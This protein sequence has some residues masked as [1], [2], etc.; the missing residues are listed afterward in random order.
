MKWSTENVFIDFTDKKVK[1]SRATVRALALKETKCQCAKCKNT[2]K[3]WSEKMV[4]EL[5]H[6][7]GNRYNHKKDNLEWLC[8][9]CHSLTSNFRGRKN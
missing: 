2:G 8:P 6:I 3:W 5:H 7:D 1:P 9:N 4:L